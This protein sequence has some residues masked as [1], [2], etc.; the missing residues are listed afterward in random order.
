MWY[1]GR[2]CFESKSQ[3][4]DSLVIV[5]A[6]KM[7]QGVVIKV[8]DGASNAICHLQIWFVVFVRFEWMRVVGGRGNVECSKPKKG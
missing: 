4:Y 7:S 1:V 6:Q 3:H 8:D 2:K 5:A